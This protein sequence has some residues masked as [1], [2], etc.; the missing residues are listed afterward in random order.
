MV[1]DAPWRWGSPQSHVD[2]PTVPAEQVSIRLNSRSAGC[3][4]GGTLGTPSLT[5]MRQ[6]ARVRHIE[7]PIA[8]VHRFCARAWTS[9][10]SVAVQGYV[11]LSISELSTNPI[12][13]PSPIPR[14]LCAGPHANL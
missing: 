2:V 7:P 11:D 6:T 5:A 3:D 13:P 1:V 9:G 12:R 10:A 4:A 8:E 14:G